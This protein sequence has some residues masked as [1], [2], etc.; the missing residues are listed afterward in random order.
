ML[1]SN[2]WFESTY[3]YLVP[4]TITAMAVLDLNLFCCSS[5]LQCFIR[6]VYKNNS[7]SLV[8][9]KYLT[10]L[11]IFEISFYLHIYVKN[12]AQITIKMKSEKNYYNWALFL[13]VFQRL[14]AKYVAKFWMDW[15]IC[16][17]VLKV[18]FYILKKRMVHIFLWFQWS[19]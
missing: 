8:I 17:K 10:D 3:I 9:Q 16:R 1:W 5:S 11:L 4:I 15:Q 6:T 13:C 19:M 14:R 12:S 2:F 18:N 7:K